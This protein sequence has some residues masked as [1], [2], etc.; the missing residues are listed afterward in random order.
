MM[1]EISAKMIFIPKHFFTH[2]VEIFDAL[3]VVVAWSLDVALL[4]DHDLVHS[5]VCKCDHLLNLENSLEF[6]MRILTSGQLYN[7]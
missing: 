1:I 7:K 5:A 4:V 6:L 2:K 3:V